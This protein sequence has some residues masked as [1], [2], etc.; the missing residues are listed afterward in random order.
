[1]SVRAGQVRY[2]D[3]RTGDSLPAEIKIAD[4]ADL[5]TVRQPI[6]L[7]KVFFGPRA[8]DALLTRRRRTTSFHSKTA[9]DLRIGAES[10]AAVETAKKQL[11]RDFQCH[12]DFRL[13][14]QYSPEAAVP[15]I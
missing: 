2:A 1:V 13:F 15:S 10:F 14:Q 4:V 7:K 3:T 6:V 5:T 12:F 8:A 11:L 9:T